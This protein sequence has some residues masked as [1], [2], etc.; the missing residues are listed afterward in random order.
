MWGAITLFERASDSREV[1]SCT[2]SVSREE[3]EGVTQIGVRRSAGW[4]RLA[5]LTRAAGGQGGPFVGE[6][7]PGGD[8]SEQLIRRKAGSCLSVQC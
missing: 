7:A 5:C 8:S 4:R 6:D 3:T 2:H 1:S